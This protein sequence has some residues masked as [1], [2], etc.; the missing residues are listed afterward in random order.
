MQT[1]TLP[2]SLVMEQDLVIVSKREYDR[3]NDF[4]RRHNEKLQEVTAED[5][6]NWSREAKQLKKQGKLKSFESLVKKEYPEFAK[7]YVL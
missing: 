6:L 4:W 5:V 1:L 2:P 7:K 3:L